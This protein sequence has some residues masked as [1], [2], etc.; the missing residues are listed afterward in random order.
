MTNRGWIGVGLQALAGVDLTGLARF[1]QA[2]MVGVPMRRLTCLIPLLLSAALR[3]E[4]TPLLQ[5][6]LNKVVQDTDRWAYTQTLV[7]KD[8]NGKQRSVAVVRFDPSKPCAEQYTALTINGQAPD[9]EDRR[10][11]RRQGERRGHR[12]DR[13]EREGTTTYRKTLGELMDLDRATITGETEQFVTYEVP[14]KKEGN[15][16]FPPEKFHVTARVNKQQQAFEN[17]SVRLRQSIREKILLKISE[18]EGTLDFTVVDPKFPPQL[19]SIVG[20][21]SGSILFVPVGR[22]YELKRE[23]FKRVKPYQERFG[24]QIGPLKALDF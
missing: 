19:T 8:R 1:G 17:I 4:M 16:R 5:E 14:F 3:A 12:A 22:G 23:D 2:L 15:N 7:E 6:A 10:K 21:G 9:A 24:V 20:R 11:Y 18:G 13:A